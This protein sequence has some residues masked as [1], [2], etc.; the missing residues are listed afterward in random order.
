V[1]A[2]AAHGLGLAGDALAGR[3]VEAFG[4]D[5]GEGHIAVELGVVGQVDALLATLTEE[6]LDF[7]AAVGEGGGLSGWLPSENGFVAWML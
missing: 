6:A 2:E 7:V 5:Q 1:G 3:V 4:L